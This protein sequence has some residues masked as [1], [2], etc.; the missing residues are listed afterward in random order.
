VDFLQ[1]RSNQ[2]LAAPYSVR[3]WPGATVSTPLRWTEVRPGLHPEQ[4]TMFN[5]FK[6][7]D[8]QGDL[9]RPV[10]GKGIN[11]KQVLSRLGKIQV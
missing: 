9:W 11:L 1:N 2:T 8:K 7:L 3:P 6:R 10:I 5:I 4:F